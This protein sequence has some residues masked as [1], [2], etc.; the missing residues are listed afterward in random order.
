METNKVKV[1]PTPTYIPM[2]G[3]PKGKSAKHIPVKKKLEKIAQRLPTMSKKKPDAK[4]T[5]KL[6]I[7]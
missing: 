2:L 6:G 4:I 5:N 7:V 1:T 3:D